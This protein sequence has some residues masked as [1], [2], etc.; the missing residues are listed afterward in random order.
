MMYQSAKPP[1][2]VQEAFLKTFQPPSVRSARDDMG[3]QKWE[4]VSGSE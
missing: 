4:P 3:Y 2:V 1:E